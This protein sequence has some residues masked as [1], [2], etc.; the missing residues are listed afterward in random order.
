MRKERGRLVTLKPVRLT[1]GTWPDSV[2]ANPLKNSREDGNN[3]IFHLDSHQVINPAHLATRNVRTLDKA[4]SCQMACQRV[5]RFCHPFVSLWVKK[6]WMETYN[7]KKTYKHYVSL[8]RVCE[9]LGDW[10]L[11]HVNPWNKHVCH[12]SIM[13]SKRLEIFLSCHLC[14]SSV[15]AKLYSYCGN[16]L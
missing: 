4:A 11:P 7:N 5:Q 10:N 13:I 8:L 14:V 15:S 6:T 1:G 12:T 3:S 9:R 16:T 2:T